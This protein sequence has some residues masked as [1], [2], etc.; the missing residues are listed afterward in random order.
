M[1]LNALTENNS[2]QK[3]LQKE[4]IR[5][6]ISK[7]GVVFAI[8][9]LIL[10]FSLSTTSFFDFANFSNVLKQASIN[11]FIAIGIMMIIVTGGID[12]SVGSNVAVTCITVSLLLQSGMSTAL[13]IIIA[14]IVATI[15][16]ICNGLAISYTAVPAFIVTL[17]TQT[18]CRG[19]ALIISKG[20][21]I[22][23]NNPFMKW[24]GRE[25]ILGIPTS[26]VILL[27][28]AILSWVIMNRTKIGRY[29]YAIGGNIET[30]KLSGIN[31]AKYIT[32]TY[33]YM[34]FLCGIVSVIMSGRLASGTP[35][36]GI[37]Y[38]LDAIA[39]AVLGGTAF[40]GGVGTVLGSLL[41]AVFIGILNNGMTLLNV[42]PYLQN[43]VRGL[44]IF[45]SVLISVL[46]SRKKS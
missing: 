38:E 1:K 30:A 43:V 6:N 22:Y 36:I 21:P 18:I 4:Q 14:I 39:A 12:L 28:F 23:V 29:I 9:L 11:G 45:L 32:F 13:A 44:V 19:L 33:A 46:S 2:T 37:G 42:S 25:N 41:G 26:I 7:Y 17:S 3:S 40:T 35:T 5:E 10:V 27:I 34:G 24:L 8:L 31:V 15:I 20:F 16:G